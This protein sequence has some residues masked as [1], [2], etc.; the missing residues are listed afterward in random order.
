MPWLSPHSNHC[1]LAVPTLTS[2]KPTRTCSG[3]LTPSRWTVALRW[4]N[5]AGAVET[6][7]A[8]VHGDDT[9]HQDFR[10]RYRAVA[11]SLSFEGHMKWAEA[12]P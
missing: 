9:A 6:L 8:H 10:D 2:T 3:W 12:M 5:L 1:W 11:T 4:G 7:L